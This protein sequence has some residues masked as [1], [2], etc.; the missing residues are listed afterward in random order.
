MKRSNF[1]KILSGLIALPFIPKA[2]A[3]KTVLINGYLEVNAEDLIVTSKQ[4]EG[5]NDWT[6]AVGDT[7]IDNIQGAINQGI[8]VGSFYTG[9]TMELK[10]DLNKPV[11]LKSTK[12][13][14]FGYITAHSVFFISFN[15]FIF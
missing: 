11:F 7:I 4:S 14:Y 9:S 3:K 12:D 15:S 13:K 1:L 2:E 6:I 5:F 10:L 8:F